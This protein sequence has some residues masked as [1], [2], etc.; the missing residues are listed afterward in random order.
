MLLEI[1]ADA[2]LDRTE[3]VVRGKLARKEKVS[4]FGHRVYK[5]EDPA[6]RT[7][8]ACRRPSA[9]RPGSRSGTR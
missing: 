7:C 4:G 9:R 2:G 1:G 5:T 8:G 3:T 6:R